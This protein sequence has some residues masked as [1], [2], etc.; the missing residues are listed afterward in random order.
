MFS[1]YNNYRQIVIEKLIKIQFLTTQIWIWKVQLSM[2]PWINLDQ[3]KISCFFLLPILVIFSLVYLFVLCF[4]RCRR[5]LWFRFE[6][7]RFIMYYLWCHDICPEDICSDDNC[8]VFWNNVMKPKTWDLKPLSDQN[9]K[10]ICNLSLNL[11]LNLNLNLILILNLILNLN[12]IQNLNFF[13]SKTPTHLSFN[14]KN[15][16]K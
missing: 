5:E 6:L 2:N 12:L 3:C 15:L 16:I 1:M 14:L 11:S 7:C 13:F 10:L 4:F 9:L 8:P